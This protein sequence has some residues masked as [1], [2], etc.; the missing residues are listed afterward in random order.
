MSR[1]RIGCLFVAG[2]A[3]GGVTLTALWGRLAP[4]ATAQASLWIAPEAGLLASAPDEAPMQSSAWVELLRS[5]MVVDETVRRRGLHVGHEAEGS[6]EAR[7]RAAG[8]ELSDALVTRMDPSGNILHLAL[9]GATAEEAV[10][11]LSTL[12]EEYVSVAAHLKRNRLEE[13]V[14]LLEAQLEALEVELVESQVALERTRIESISTEPADFADRVAEAQAVRDLRASTA[15]YEEVSERHRQARLEFMS[16]MPDVRF[17]D[18]AHIRGEAPV[19]AR[20]A[21]GLVVVFA[22]LF[23]ALSGAVAWN[24]PRDAMRGSW[25]LAGGRLVQD[26]AP[27]LAIAASGALVALAVGFTLSLM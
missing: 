24:L 16:S 5:Y 13:Q 19:G 10:T 9:E 15:L 17:L 25:S 18:R 11:L 26:V 27:A 23:L 4:P 12:T 7:I 6:E 1:L 20:L 2:L 22:G 3:L 14:A 21:L 8:K